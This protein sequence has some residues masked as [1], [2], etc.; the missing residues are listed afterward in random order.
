MREY[1][2]HG[3]SSKY[4]ELREKFDVLFRSE[5]AKYLAKIQREVAECKRGSIYPILKK[6]SLRPGDTPH[7]SFQ[8][9]IHAGLSPSQIAEVISTYF[10]SISQEYM[11]LKIASLPPNL[12]KSLKNADQ[13]LAPTLTI[14]DV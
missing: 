14:K 13:S 11:P 3:Q 2:K 10:S 12:Q 1:N 9:P 5:R 8:L 4:F 6:L 7:G